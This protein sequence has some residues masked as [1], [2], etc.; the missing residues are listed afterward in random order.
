MVDQMKMTWCCI[1]IQFFC[2]DIICSFTGCTG[3]IYNE[4]ARTVTSASAPYLNNQFLIS[5]ELDV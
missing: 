5:F 2:E 1:I 4:T 3:N